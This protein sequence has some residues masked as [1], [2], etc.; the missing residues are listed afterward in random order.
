MT[1]TMLDQPM[2]DQPLKYRFIESYATSRQ[3]FVS[4]KEYDLDPE[5]AAQVQLAGIAEWIDDDSILGEAVNVEYPAVTE[6]APASKPPKRK[7]A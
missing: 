6:V 4:G 2:R 5:T 7:K 3:H 1:N